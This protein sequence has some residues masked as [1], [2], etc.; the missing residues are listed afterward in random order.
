M[1]LAGFFFITTITAA[2]LALF[3]PWW[4]AAIAAAIVAF[5]MDVPTAKAFALGF[6]ALSFLWLSYA[7]FIEIQA[8]TLTPLSQRIAD[9]FKVGNANYIYLITAIIGGLTGGLGASCGSSIRSIFK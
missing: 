3:L 9:V 7:L 1:K 6:A 2:I 5:V 8:T 4:T